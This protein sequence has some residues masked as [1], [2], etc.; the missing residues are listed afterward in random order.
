MIRDGVLVL[1]VGPRGEGLALRR[2]AAARQAE[3]APSDTDLDAAA[4]GEP[5]PRAREPDEERLLP[6][7]TDGVLVD[8]ARAAV[9]VEPD[10]SASSVRFALAPLA[11][12][13]VELATLAGSAPYVVA[14]AGASIGYAL[15]STDGESALVAFEGRSL[16]ASTAIDLD[17]R[18]ALG[19]TFLDARDPARDRVK[20]VCDDAGATLAVHALDGTLRARECTA[21]GAC[22]GEVDLGATAGFDV[23]RVDG[24][25]LLATTR[26]EGGA[27]WVRSILRGPAHVAA[28]CFSDGE[29]LCGRPLIAA[30]GGGRMVLVTR[31]RNDLAAVESIDGGRTWR[32]MR[33]VR[34]DDP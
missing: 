20:L 3:S 13:T 30:G 23:A 32:T 16:L 21:R 19:R 33:G 28:P 12:E 27:V 26:S 5:P 17:A 18:D 7:A 34:D 1:G 10:A 24:R 31:E 25:S 22:G 9:V 15:L 8:G 6:D 29:G 2:F 14:C 11:G 4:P